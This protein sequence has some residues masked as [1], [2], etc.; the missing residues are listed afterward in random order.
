MAGPNNAIFCLKPLSL[1][2]SLSRSRAR[3]NS[4]FLRVSLSDEE[5]V[6]VGYEF[7]FNNGTKGKEILYTN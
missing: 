4:T 7:L 6:E 3:V 2:L 1:S 5:K